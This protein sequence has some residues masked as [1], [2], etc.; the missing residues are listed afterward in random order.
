MEPSVPPVVSIL[1]ASFTVSPQMS[2]IGF[3]APMVR[4]ICFVFGTGLG[5]G[6]VLQ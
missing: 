5:N 3:V 1:E 6:T 4:E 2:K